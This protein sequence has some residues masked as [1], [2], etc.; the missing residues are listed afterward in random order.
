[1]AHCMQ[2]TTCYYNYGMTI[3]LNKF[4]RQFISITLNTGLC[5]FNSVVHNLYFTVE[6]ASSPY[7]VATSYAFILHAPPPKFQYTST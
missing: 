1:M 5:H 3:V 6:Y 2:A 4:G 7:I